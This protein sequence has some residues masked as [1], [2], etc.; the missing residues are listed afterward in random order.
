MLPELRALPSFTSMLTADENMQRWRLASPAMGWR[1]VFA[2]ARVV[3]SGWLT[4]GQ[5][6]YDFEYDFAK[7][8]QV[9]PRLV[10]ACN[11]GTSA[12]TVAL[13][14]HDRPSRLQRNGGGFG[15]RN[16]ARIAVPTLTYAGS[17]NAIFAAGLEPHL[18]DVDPETWCMSVDSFDRSG[19]M[20]NNVTGAL[21]VHLYGYLSDVTPKT[22]GHQYTIVEDACEALGARDLLGR[23]GVRAN[24][25][26]FSLF[27]NKQVSAGEGGIIVAQDVA[28]ANRCRV[29]RGQGQKG[30][31]SDPGLRYVHT[32]IGVNARML[33]VQAALGIQSLRRFRKRE[34]AHRMRL[35]TEYRRAFR[36][37]LVSMRDE[38]HFVNFEK[39][40]LA[41]PKLEPSNYSAMF[42]GRKSWREAPWLCAVQLPFDIRMTRFCDQLAHVGI[43]SR[44]MF[45]P[46][47]EQPWWNKRMFPALEPGAFPIAEAVSRTAIALPL[48]AGLGPL[49]IRLIAQRVCELAEATRKRMT[50]AE[51]Y[52]A[53]FFEKDAVVKS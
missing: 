33:E 36:K 7:Y 8:M 49:D 4:Q 52:A 17:V 48:H 9:D 15:S 39:M 45:T 27:A 43:E 47:H 6:V 29:I 13:M 12:L 26:V 46:L 50:S 40:M 42:E 14:S 32:E 41:D 38:R 28:Q 5:V 37:S 11:N 10:V 51:H 21:P 25:G 3:R 23:A 44:P 18:T 2:V 19:P 1:D 34:S 35:M 20:A 16:D 24:G 53:E 31:T 30:Q 22:I